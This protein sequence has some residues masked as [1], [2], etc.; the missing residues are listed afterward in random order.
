MNRK[1]ECKSAT[2]G[3]TFIYTIRVS[4]TT[5]F[6]VQTS[7]RCKKIQSWL[8]SYKW[9]H[10]KALHR[11]KVNLF[12]VIQ[13]R[14]ASTNKEKGILI[15][16]LFS[17]SEM[18]RSRFIRSWSQLIQSKNKTDFWKNSE[19]PKHLTIRQ[20]RFSPYLQVLQCYGSYFQAWSRN[21]WGTFSS[22]HWAEG[23]AGR[24]WKPWAVSLCLPKR[25]GFIQVAHSPLYLLHL[26]LGKHMK[27]S[28]CHAFLP[29][30][31]AFCLQHIH[32]IR[33][34][35]FW[36]FLGGKQAPVVSKCYKNGFLTYL[37]FMTKEWEIEERFIILI[38]GTPLAACQKMGCSM[39]TC[40][41][42][43][44]WVWDK[45]SSWGKEKQVF[46]DFADG[47]SGSICVCLCWLT[48]ASCLFIKEHVPINIFPGS[49]T[50]V[51]SAQWHWIA[52]VDIYL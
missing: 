15:A 47:K 41:P 21:K 28:V 43:V 19:L 27:V 37:F 29:A 45:S 31:P 2:E 12:N 17:L 26:C 30:I 24:A 49:E 35:D 40:R 52:L 14:L 46:T 51:W 5:C 44:L 4:T 3:I 23:Q 38:S 25:E 34:R 32:V 36:D 11:L 7:E 48:A 20:D 18:G 13:W 8:R 42:W 1:K 33:R 16:E 22:L 50:A 6:G 39:C 9:G 10:D